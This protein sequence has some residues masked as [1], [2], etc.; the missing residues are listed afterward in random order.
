MNENYPTFEKD[1]KESNFSFKSDIGVEE[2][3]SSDNT[4]ETAEKKKAGKRIS[5]VKIKTQSINEI[6]VMN[7]NLTV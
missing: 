7:K 3:N 2:I 6:E 5:I 4:V 1:M